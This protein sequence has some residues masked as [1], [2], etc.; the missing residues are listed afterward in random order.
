MRSAAQ[1]IAI[2]AASLLAQSSA[3]AAT[4]P[5]IGQLGT[6]MHVTNAGALPAPTIAGPG[7]ADVNPLGG[8]HLTQASL[9]GGVFA[10]AAPGH[11]P[12][13]D[14]NVFPIAG[15]QLSATNAAGLV[16]APA[17]GPLA[18][19]IPL[20]GLMKVCLYA[21]CGA[22]S[23]ISNL[24]IP[25][26]VVGQ[27]GT[28]FKAGAVNMT[29]IGA[30]WTT[31]T[32]AVGTVTAQG[33]A[34]GPASQASST[35]QPGGTLNLVAPMY[36]S[37][38][39]GALAEIPAFARLQLVFGATPD[40]ANGGDDD[41]DGHVDHPADPGCES[42]SDASEQQSG[43]D[44]DD[45]LDNDGDGDVDL[46]DSG[47]DASTDPSEISSIACANTIDDD[48]DGYTDLFDPG[49]DGPTDPSEDSSLLVCDDGLD[50]DGDGLV[51]AFADPD[52]ADLFDPDES[53]ECTDGLDNDGDGLVDFAADP[54]CK[55][56]TGIRENAQCQDGWDNDNDGRID[57]DGGASHNGGV[58]QAAADPQ[59]AHAYQ[60]REL[61]LC[62]VGAELVVVVGAL[63]LWRRRGR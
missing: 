59:C 24:E 18:G 3:F 44:C 10:G 31:G 12:V 13:T 34:R 41:G 49:C 15:L 52:C 42:A 9:A 43:M 63:A 53:S 51:D 33:S 8:V 57:F 55:G 17:T 50:N 6:T 38:H 35:A 28:V 40:C 22:S 25:L 16:A 62:G 54:G 39:I 32:A 48:G 4:L 60:N 27:G 21:D 36:I 47:C 37:T 20:Q 56:S 19:T 61:V 14:P 46:A 30:P 5:F 11:V 29:V 7:V 23:N 45:G 1:A 2:V 58:P 26:S